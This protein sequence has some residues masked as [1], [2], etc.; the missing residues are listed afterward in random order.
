MMIKLFLFFVFSHLLSLSSPT[1]ATADS[2]LSKYHVTTNV[3][4][5]L[6]HTSIAMVFYNPNEA[7]SN[8]H[9]LN[10]QLPRNARLTD[11]VMNLSDGC[12]LNSTVKS[13]ETAKDAFQQ[14]SSSGKPAALLTAWDMAN[15][16]IKVSIP[17]NGTTQVL[18]KYQ[19]LL[20]QK[21]G[22]VTFQVPFFP[23]IRVDELQVDISVEENKTGINDFQVK[24]EDFQTLFGNTT[25][26]AYSKRSQL[27]EDSTLPRLFE[28]YYRPGLLPEDGLFLSDGEC[29][30][31]L[32]NPSTFLSNAGPMSRRIVFV[33]DV[34]GMYAHTQ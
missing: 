13:L 29:F 17:S 7:C 31:H 22:R 19:E 30:T 6:A 3:R 8:I 24:L 27:S 26:Y 33:I 25:S 15:Y 20:W 18:L 28:A 4:S 21:L 11:L 1:E 32:F 23:G 2:F 9:S 14:A 16:N 5:R 10:V 12:E 34:S